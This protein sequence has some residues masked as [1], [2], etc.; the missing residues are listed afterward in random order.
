MSTYTVKNAIL[1]LGFIEGCLQSHIQGTSPREK[2]IWGVFDRIEQRITLQN[3]D[4]AQMLYDLGIIRGAHWLASLPG[5]YSDAMDRLMEFFVHGK[6]DW[7]QLPQPF[8]GMEHEDPLLS[9]ELRDEIYSDYVCESRERAIETIKRA[10]FEE[11]YLIDRIVPPRVKYPEP[12]KP[13]CV[14][15]TKQEGIKV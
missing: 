6:V 10:G 1:D 7:Y 4:S 11:Q 13:A 5:S 9:D 14:D 3:L 2:Y 8:T 15:D 12:P